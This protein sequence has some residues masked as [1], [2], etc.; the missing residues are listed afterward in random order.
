M[1]KTP[2][3]SMI[4][5]YRHASPKDGRLEHRRKLSTWRNLSPGRTMPT[6][7]GTRHKMN[8][9]TRSAEVAT[10]TSAASPSPSISS[11]AKKQAPSAAAA[12]SRGK[13]HRPAPWFYLSRCH[14]HRRPR[15][16]RFY[17]DTSPTRTLRGHFVFNP[18]LTAIKID[19][20][21]SL[22]NT[23]PKDQPRPFLSGLRPSIFG[24]SN[25][26]ARNTVARPN[27]HPHSWE[28]GYTLPHNASYLVDKNTLFD[29]QYSTIPG[30]KRK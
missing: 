10:A 8:T 22:R 18:S 5:S 26:Q 23:T 4:S 15:R 1:A 3:P 9:N 7:H 30:K 16:V 25:N 20:N 29:Y 21:A 2:A 17:L 12:V 19:S 13:L 24:C 14:G 28:V 6:Q 27:V 11:S